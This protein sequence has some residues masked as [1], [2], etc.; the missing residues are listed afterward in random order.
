MSSMR[1][2]TLIAASTLLVLPSCYQLQISAQAAYARMAIDGDLGYVS[3]STTASIQQDVKSAFGLGDDQGIPYGRLTIDTGVPVLAVS[4]FAFDEQG[5]GVLNASF[6][7][8]PNLI[9]GAGVRT[10]FQMKNAKVSYAFQ[11][12]LGPVKI[13]PGLA[14][15]YFD[16]DIEVRD[17][18]G[19]ARE[20]V[21]LQAPIPMGFL[22]GE[23][24]L[25][26]VSA[27]VEVG[28]MQIDIKDV[29]A[30]LLDIEALLMV[31]PW[32]LFDV[33]VGYR[34]LGFQAD[35]LIDNNSFDTDLT[36]SGLLI[37][38]GITF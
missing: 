16:L 8:N 4:G 10:D 11:I 32:S 22:R 7:S 18:I 5:T 3:G 24:D 17:L 34:S 26:V 37:G 35:G 33:F 21:Q 14:V 9:A 19:I 25:S 30:K 13:S 28:Y 38:G 15:D 27:V 36:I 2:L 29:Q 6:G 31:H 12:S 23:V 1:L 20:N